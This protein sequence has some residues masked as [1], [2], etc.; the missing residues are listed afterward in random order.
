M[1]LLAINAMIAASLLSLD[2]PE[3]AKVNRNPGVYC[4]WTCIDVVQRVHNIKPL[5]GLLRERWLAR[6]GAP[7]PGYPTVVEAALK[8]RHVNYHFCDQFSYNRRLLNDYADKYGVIVALKT[9]NPFSKFC[10]SILVTSYDQWTVQFYCPDA[11][12]RF[13]CSR[14][15]FDIWWLGDSLVIFPEDHDD[16]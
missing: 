7:D 13:T 6:N 5:K 11:Q 16:N 4:T 3:E 14:E 15:W 8:Q 12:K 10:H 9:G 1:G 2:I